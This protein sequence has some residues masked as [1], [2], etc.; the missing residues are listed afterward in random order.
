MALDPI[1]LINVRSSSVNKAF[2]ILEPGTAVTVES[3]L[4]GAEDIY[5]YYVKDLPVV[6]EIMPSFASPVEAPAVEQA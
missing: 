1:T 4:A 5:N 2:E 6:P 3:V